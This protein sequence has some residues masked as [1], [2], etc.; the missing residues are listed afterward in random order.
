MANSYYS[1]RVDSAANTLAD[2]KAAL[3]DTYGAY[4]DPANLTGVRFDYDTSPYLIFRSSAIADAYIRLYWNSNNPVFSYGDGVSG[5]NVT[6][7][8]AFGGTSTAGSMTEAHLVLGPHTLL[9]QSLQ[10]TQISRLVIIGQLTN[11]DYAVLSCS[12]SSSSIYTTSHYAYNTTD[13]ARLLPVTLDHGFQGA[14][15]KLYTQRLILAGYGAGGVELNGDGSVAGY[16]DLYNASHETSN[17]GYVWGATF[18]LS[19]SKM[20]MDGAYPVLDTCLLMEFE[21]VE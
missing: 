11:N 10:S 2:F 21:A 15:G 17:I 19:L 8:V 4:N 3:L 12:G 7:P 18:V 5:N 16:Q 14:A 1:I 20:Y 6:N 9:W 13:A